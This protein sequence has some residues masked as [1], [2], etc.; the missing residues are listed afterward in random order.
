MIQLIKLKEKQWF[1]I[2]IAALALYTVKSIFVGADVDEAYGVTLGYRLV[3]G[4]RLLWDMWEPHQTSAI[5]TAA[6]IRLILFFTGGSLNYMTILLRVCFFIIQTGIALYLYKCFEECLPFISRWE[7]ALFA[8]VYYIT[9]PKCN[10][11]PE[12]SNLHMWFSTMLVLFLM[13]YFCTVSRNHGKA[14]YLAL[15]GVMLS[16]DVLAYPGMV[17][18]YPFCALL[19]LIKSHPERKRLAEL[20]V[21]TLPCIIGAG[22]FMAYI[23]SYMSPNDIKTVLPYVMGDGSHQTSV[24]DKAAA[25]FAGL[26]D[27]MLMIAGCGAAAAIVYLLQN[28]FSGAKERKDFV[29]RLLFLWFTAQVIFQ[30]IYWM[31]TD[32]N[33][34]YPQIAYIAVPIFGLVCI[35]FSVRKENVGKYMIG[36]ALLNFIVLNLS[37]NWGPE[38][39]TVYLVI[40]L[41]GGL[42]CWRQYF[43]EK[44]GEHGIKL[45]RIICVM[46]ILSETFGRCLLMIGGDD[47][48]S[49]T[50]QV[51][52]ISHTGVRGG[53][54]TSYMNSYRYN[55]N[56]ELFP[57]IVPEGSMILYLGPSQ[58]YYMLGDCR[59]ASP[60]TIST[61]IYDESLEMYYKIHP[62]RFPD[63]VIM[64]SCYGDVS[65]FAEDDYVFTWIDEE[66]KPERVEEYPY[67]RVYYRGNETGG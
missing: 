54:F 27:L 41:L 2:L 37:S 55:N 9:T 1:K 17:I 53:I 29:V 38:S 18:F 57:E 4:D 26:G 28:V 22:I 24:A 63:V 34:G 11:V 47:G 13:Q 7:R 45:M 40:G 32:Y 64:E 65:F 3:Q 56:Y 61:P 19:I 39:L 50:F 30:I 12:Y 46:F 60:T 44:S 5:F 31:D 23:L 62:E 48:S 67:V 35:Y 21:F 15:A 36:S 14:I 58:F 52:G 6:F 20:C 49:M 16:C 25:L 59:I 10:Y 42:L 33:S 43:W 51:R 66:F 8:M